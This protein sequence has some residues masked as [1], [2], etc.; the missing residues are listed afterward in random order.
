MSLP[1]IDQ[2]LNRTVKEQTLMGE[3]TLA[4]GFLS[5]KWKQVQQLWETQSPSNV[6]V[7]QWESEVI[8]IVQQYTY[9]VWKR[10]NDTLHGET[11]RE[12]IEKKKQKLLNS[13]WIHKNPLIKENT[14]KMT[15]NQIQK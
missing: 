7:E 10:R 9:A 15:P 8:Q 1:H 13:N 2:E 11:K 5:T 4:K 3:D 12:C 14:H 6:H